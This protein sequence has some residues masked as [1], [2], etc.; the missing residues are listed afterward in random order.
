[1]GDIERV[2]L[3]KQ[4]VSR[5]HRPKQPEWIDTLAIAKRHKG[6]LWQTSFPTHYLGAA[7]HMTFGYKF[8]PHFHLGF[9][10]GL[11]AMVKPVVYFNQMPEDASGTDA[12]VYLPL[13]LHIGGD[14]N[15]NHFT[16]YYQFRLGA[17]INIKP[18]AFSIQNGH[19]LDIGATFGFKAYS[20]RR[21]YFTLGLSTNVKH[22]S[23][24][25]KTYIPDK[26]YIRQN[27]PATA[28]F[29]GIYIGFGI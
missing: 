22:Y 4:K 6:F 25:Y 18:E 23:V 1:V 16:P 2:H 11:E 7:M 14:V 3:H 28:L 20:P 21:K 9:L 13:A 15:T 10:T 27:T 8:N 5:R 12:T 19:A 29:L 17:D 24:S 26:G